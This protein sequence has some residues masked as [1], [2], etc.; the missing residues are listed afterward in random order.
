MN[1]AAQRFDTDGI[2]QIMEHLAENEKTWAEHFAGH[3][4]DP[5]TVDRALKV[6]VPEG[7]GRGKA[8][9]MG[10]ALGLQLGAMRLEPIPYEPEREKPCNCPVC[11]LRR[12]LEDAA[13]GGTSEE[14]E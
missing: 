9:A 10:F 12:A 11:L 14:P 5:V 8:A 6:I 2:V 13:G 3:D 7:D 4:L 1:D